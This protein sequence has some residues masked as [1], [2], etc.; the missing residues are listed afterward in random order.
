MPYLEYYKDGRRL[1]LNTGWSSSLNQYNR[2]LLTQEAD[3]VTTHGTDTFYFLSFIAV[4]LKNW[5]SQFSV[6]NTK[7]FRAELGH[8]WGSEHDPDTDEC[9]PSSFDG[10][11]YIMY[12]YSVSG[13]DPNNKVSPLSLN[14]TL[15]PFFCLTQ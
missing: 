1:Y 7:C 2:R 15:I 9:S 4:E 11:K 5:S 12:T 14:V 13:Y 8:N 6:F 3:L 10:G